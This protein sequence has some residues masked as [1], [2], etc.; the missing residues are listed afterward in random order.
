MPSPSMSAPRGIYQYMRSQPSFFCGTPQWHVF[1]SFSRRSPLKYE[2][3]PTVP[4]SINASNIH[5]LTQPQIPSEHI[6][7][8]SVLNNIAHEKIK[9]TVQ[10]TVIFA[11]YDCPPDD[12]VSYKT[13]CHSSI[14]PRTQRSSNIFIQTKTVCHKKTGT[15]GKRRDRLQQLTGP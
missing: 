9:A 2:S 10:S 15:V 12:V 6:C 4:S 13:Q 7:R 3:I 5:P 11:P 14:T 8:Q 1:Y